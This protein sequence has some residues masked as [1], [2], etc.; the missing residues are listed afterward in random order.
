MR[1]RAVSVEVIRAAAARRR[2]ARLPRPPGRRLEGDV[3]ASTS[4]SAA[5]TTRRDRRESP[6]GGRGG[7]PGARSSPS[8]RSIRPTAVYAEQPWPDDERPHADALVTDRPGLL[9][10]I[11]TADCTP[12]LLADREAGVI[13]AAH[14]GWRGALAGVTDATIAAMERL[15]AERDRIA[16]AVGPCIAASSYE[17]D[18]AFRAASPRPTPSNERFF[19]PGRD[20]QPQF[21]LEAYVVARLAEAGV[22]PRRGARPRHLCRAG[23][24]LQLPPRHPPRRADL[25]P[26]DQHDRPACKADLIGCS[27]PG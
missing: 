16:A 27:R 19:S 20:G 11:L 24:L 23:P 21:D 4:A 10:G 26:P 15:G 3:R 22:E 6:P 8:T 5:A 7:A 14:A 17:V 9:L 13:G 18:D 1:L 2:A 25:R 12:V